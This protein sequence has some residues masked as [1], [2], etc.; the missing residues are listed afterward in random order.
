MSSAVGAGS[1]RCPDDGLPTW[2][3]LTQ[4]NDLVL[5]CPWCDSRV[6]TL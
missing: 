5:R 3:E 6:F 4:G 1:V 2:L